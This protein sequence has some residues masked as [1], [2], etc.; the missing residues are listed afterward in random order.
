MCSIAFLA[1]TWT[2]L[3]YGGE[4]PAG[5]FSVALPVTD[6][7]A[8][9]RDPLGVLFEDG[10]RHQAV[11]ANR[12]T[13][14]AVAIVSPATQCSS[15]LERAGDRTGVSSAHHHSIPEGH[16]QEALLGTDLSV[17]G[18]AAFVFRVAND[19]VHSLDTIATRGLETGR[20]AGVLIIEITIIACFAAAQET[21]TAARWGAESSTVIMV[22]KIA[23]IAKFLPVHDT[24]SAD[25]CGQG[26]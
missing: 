6:M 2:C 25:R 17:R 5:A 3:A 26:A 1:G 22:F 8:P 12:L 19:L 4:A 10:S 14:C 21:I 15:A 18:V 11:F 20:C 7:S 23:I 16:G 13:Q 24:V 9:N